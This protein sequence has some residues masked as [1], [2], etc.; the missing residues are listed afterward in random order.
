MAMDR[1]GEGKWKVT[2]QISST[3]RLDP[4]P[5]LIVSEDR[6]SSLEEAMDFACQ[7]PMHHKAVKLEG[8]N[9]TMD[10]DEIARQC[11]SRR[12]R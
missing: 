1:Q 11:K 6:F 12:S 2:V 5:K 9:M 8:P 7:Q 3:L 4:G 10:E